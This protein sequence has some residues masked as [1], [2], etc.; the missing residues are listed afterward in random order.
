MGVATMECLEC[1]HPT[2]AA[3]IFQNEAPNVKSTYLVDSGIGH[4]FDK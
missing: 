2:S 1:A 3:Y 4:L